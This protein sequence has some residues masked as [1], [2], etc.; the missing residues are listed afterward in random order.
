M[1][2]NRA[3][4][5]VCVVVMVVVV[6]VVAVV[7]VDVSSSTKP[8]GQIKIKS[9]ISRF[10]EGFTVLCHTSVNIEVVRCDTVR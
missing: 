3:S 5:L 10:G 4:N 2:A 1:P 9:Q 7:V 8:D 6:V